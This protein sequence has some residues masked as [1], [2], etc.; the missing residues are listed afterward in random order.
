MTGVQTCA[1]PISDY[2]LIK[3]EI[4]KVEEQEARIT[5]LGALIEEAVAAIETIEL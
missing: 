4:N 2:P 5:E 3:P 1:L